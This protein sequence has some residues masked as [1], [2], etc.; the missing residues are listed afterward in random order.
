[1]VA[2]G[3]TMVR[4]IFRLDYFKAV[5]LAKTLE[6][7]VSQDGSITPDERTNSLLVYDSRQRMAGIAELI[8]D[9]DQPVPQIMI[10]ARIVETTTNFAKELGVRWGFQYT[11]SE[12]HTSELQS[13]SFISYAVFCL[14]KKNK[15]A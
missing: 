1:M 6:K 3:D 4:R 12:E 5:E 8:K 10:E 14:K 7:A 15:I 13:H 11:R 9:L 2:K